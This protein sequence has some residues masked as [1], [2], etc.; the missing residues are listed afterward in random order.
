MPSP[1]IYIYIYIYLYVCIYIYMYLC[2]C[3]YIYVYTCKCIYILYIYIYIFLGPTRFQLCVKTFS[4]SFLSVTTWHTFLHFLKLVFLFFYNSTA[5]FQY[6]SLLFLRLLT[7]WAFLAVPWRS[8][9]YLPRIDKPLILG[10]TF[11]GCLI[12]TTW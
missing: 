4:F 8:A 12:M 6:V 9:N 7:V 3:V 11:Q 5:H 10:S 1:N 2:R